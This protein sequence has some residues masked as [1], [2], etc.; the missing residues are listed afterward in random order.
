MVGGVWACGERVV[1]LQARCA[2]RVIC[3]KRGVHGFA[4]RARAVEAPSARF[5]A[6]V[7]SARGLPS[8]RGFC[9]RSLRDA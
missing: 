1:G 9:I 4:L 6:S 5:A 3:G 8:V 2:G 7:T